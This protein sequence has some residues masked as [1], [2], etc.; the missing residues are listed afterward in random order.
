MKRSRITIHFV[1]KSSLLL[2]TKT[3]MTTMKS[4]YKLKYEKVS[5]F[6]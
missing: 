1:H 5:M 3:S 2:Y 6:V 4:F